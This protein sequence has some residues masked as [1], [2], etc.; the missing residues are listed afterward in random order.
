MV[1]MVFLI[2]TDQWEKNLCRLIVGS[3]Y[4]LQ[5][6]SLLFLLFMKSEHFTIYN[7]KEHTQMKSELGNGFF[8]QVLSWVF[9][10]K[11][12]DSFESLAFK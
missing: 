10:H 7:E 8:N 9:V 6:I 3:G 4:M 2:Y 12:L 1:A 5:N 11:L